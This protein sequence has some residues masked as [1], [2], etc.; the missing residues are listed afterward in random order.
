[1]IKITYKD[2][3][4]SIE[5]SGHAGSAPIGEDL[6]CAAAS[7]LIMA[8][9]EYMAEN[10]D[11][12]TAFEYSIDSGEAFVKAIPTDAFKKAH[13][14]AYDVIL[15]GFALLSNRYPEYILLESCI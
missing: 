7:T 1:M 9:V 8:L 5:M 6:V 13:E 11:K 14:G 4:H 12:L 3:S 15:T 10:A 2:E